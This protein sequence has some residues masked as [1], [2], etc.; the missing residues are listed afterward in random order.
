MKPI[1]SLARRAAL[2]LAATAAAAGA[3]A[4]HA[5]GS[6]A[7]EIAKYRQMLAEGNPAELWEAAGEEL[8]KKPA[9][10][11]NASLE[12]CDLGKGPGVTKGAYAELPRYFKDTNKVM[13]LEQRLAHCRMT[14]QGLSKEEATKNPFSSSGK[15]SEIERLV[16]YLTGE[17]RGVKMN[18][19]LGHPEEKRTYALGEKMF[20]Y[21]GGAYD[22]ACATCH[23][24]DG[25]R[26]RL[27]DLPNLL[28]D[29]GAQAAYTTW[30]A[31]R[32]SQGEVR[33]MQHRLYDC[34]RQQRFP[35]PAYGSDVITALTMFLAR[36]AN[37]GTYDG[38]AM[39]R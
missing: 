4:V 28:T 35:E 16:A 6:T 21:R 17:S 18:V 15:P 24:V 27:Q 26:I 1:P 19:Q 37:G 29:K 33:T 5:Q 20:F 13:D 39:K 11:K 32:V 12:Q 3:A 30:P 10:P 9:G 34:L 7:D 2:A 31:Y 22:F 14:L 23:A 25:Q 36:N 38:P 8:W